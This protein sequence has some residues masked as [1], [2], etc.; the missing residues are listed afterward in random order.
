MGRVD[1]GEADGL[2]VGSDCT[3]CIPAPIALLLVVT[4]AVVCVAVVRL[5]PEFWRGTTDRARRWDERAL[6]RGGEDALGT[7][8]SIPA[9]AA[10][11]VAL[12]V[13]MILP[14]VGEV[15]RNEPQVALADLNTIELAWFVAFFVPGIIALLVIRPLTAHRG[16]PTWAIPP[17]F[18]HDPRA[19][20]PERD[21]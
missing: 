2:M 6:A 4:M 15:V 12:P 9:I 20:R 7:L 21:P 18:R 8:R 11:F 10:A 13:S 3:L 1:L 5:L 19:R 16:V 14:L 17:R